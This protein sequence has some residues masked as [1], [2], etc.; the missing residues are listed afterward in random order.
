MERP[1]SVQYQTAEWPQR[2]TYFIK[3][4]KKKKRVSSQIQLVLPTQ[5]CLFVASVVA[6]VLCEP[7]L[8]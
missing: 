8:R 1:W 5:I 3:K 7:T 2:K 6:H 4:K